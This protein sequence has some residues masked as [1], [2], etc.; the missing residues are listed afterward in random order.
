[1]RLSAIR[2]ARVSLMAAGLA[3]PALQ[4]GPDWIGQVAQYGLNE[5]RNNCAPACMADARAVP[6]SD[7]ALKGGKVLVFGGRIYTFLRHDLFEPAI[8]RATDRDTGRTLWSRDIPPV[9]EPSD[10]YA[11]ARDEVS[12]RTRIYFATNTWP[13]I[14]PAAVFCIQDDGDASSEVWKA[15]PSQVGA[16]TRIRDLTFSGDRLFCSVTVYSAPYT[17]E[18]GMSGMA[19]LEAKTGRL[20]FYERGSHQ[21]GWGY[22]FSVNAAARKVFCVRRFDLRCLDFEGHLLWQVPL[23]A[24]ETPRFTFLDPDARHVHVALGATRG[25]QLRCY[26]ASTGDFEWSQPAYDPFTGSPFYRPACAGGLILT[27]D[28]QGGLFALDGHTGMTVWARPDLQPAQ[29]LVTA[30][31]QCLWVLIQTWGVVEN[32]LC[33]NASTGE[34]LSAFRMPGIS[35]TP[36]QPMAVDEGSLYVTHWSDDLRDGA[37]YLARI[38]HP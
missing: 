1:M 10:T 6:V 3:C 20:L 30:D 9:Y 2:A 33:L 11:C 27:T 17:V 14:A 4:A 21:E 34:T 8:L 12:G 26:K 19:A 24:G 28:A 38:T 25:T 5:A 15:F 31:H 37:R 13:H 22:G 35:G 18:P 29:M 7:H 16:R 32:F 23:P 36:A